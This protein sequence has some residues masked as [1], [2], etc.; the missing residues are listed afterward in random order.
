MKLPLKSQPT[1]ACYEIGLDSNPLPVWTDDGN[2]IDFSVALEKPV[3][4]VDIPEVPGAFQLLNLLSAAE[5]DAFVEQTEHMGF[6]LDS[7]VSL[8]HDVRHNKNLNWVVSE[9]IDRPIWQRCKSLVTETVRGQQARGINARFRFYRYGVG[10]FFSTHTDG[11]WPGSRVTDGKLL[12]NAYPKLHSQYTCL[13]FLSDEYKG[14]RTQFLVSKTDSQR[15]AMASDDVKTISVSTPKGAALC[16]PHGTH[17]QHCLH[18]GE[19]ISA[20][21]KY[22]IR[23]DILFGNP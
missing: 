19:T 20:G 21:V 15:P 14:G 12:A 2:A 4:R 16:F 13:I 10:D 11:S 6:H 3:T 9:A 18:A 1:I 7:P 22:I 5:A 17:P 23:T 8:P